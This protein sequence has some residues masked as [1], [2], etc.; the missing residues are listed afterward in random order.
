M[1]V[2]GISTNDICFKKRLHLITYNKLMQNA[3]IP[4]PQYIS[5]TYSLDELIYRVY[6]AQMLN[7][8]LYNP[9]SLCNSAILTSRN[10]TVDVINQKLLDM[11][12]GEAVTLISADKADQIGR[13]H[14]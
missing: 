11:M 12:S 2:R 4:L 7:E 9:S 6:L 8:A 13:A 3:R 1:R 14:V 10:D 5:Q